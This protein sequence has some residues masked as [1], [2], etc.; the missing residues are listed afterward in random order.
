MKRKVQYVYSGSG[1]KPVYVYGFLTDEDKDGTSGDRVK[2]EVVSSQP[3]QRLSPGLYSVK[4]LPGG[5]A[6]LL[7]DKD[8]ASQEDQ[9][10]IKAA[11]EAGFK[12]AEN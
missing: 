7:P 11:R 2:F 5:W 9:R 1:G 6:I 12:L 8:V 4:D 10:I 3:E